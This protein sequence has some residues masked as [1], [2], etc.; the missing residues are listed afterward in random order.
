MRQN[1]RRRMRRRASSRYMKTMIRKLADTASG[2]NKEQAKSLLPV[3]FSAIDRNV[4]KNLLHW[5]T[6]AR[7]K[8]TLA[9]LCQ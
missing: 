1:E 6:A 5:R 4:K 7:K 3:V 9:K 8:S 2:G